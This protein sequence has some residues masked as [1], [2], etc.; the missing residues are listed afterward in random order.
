MANQNNTTN[1]ETE[2]IQKKKNRFLEILKEIVSI[3]KSPACFEALK[4]C[5]ENLELLTENNAMTAEALD[6]LID[7]TSELKGKIGT[8]N[9]EEILQEMA[10]IEEKMKYE[11]KTNREVASSFEVALTQVLDNVPINITKTSLCV[12]VN[13]DYV[14]KM[15]DDNGASYYSRVKT[16]SLS[17]DRSISFAPPEA[18]YN[19]VK[20]E[21]LKDLTDVMESEAKFETEFMKTVYPDFCDL[22]TI[23]DEEQ[24]EK[25]KLLSD[26][27]SFIEKY[28]EIH[29]CEDNPKYN[30]RLVGNTFCMENTSAH[31]LIKF[32]QSDNAIKPVLYSN[33]E[34]GTY[35][36]IGQGISLGSIQQYPDC[37]KVNAQLSFDAGYVL[38]EAIKTEVFSDYL[39]HIGLSKESVKFMMHRE[40]IEGFHKVGD[41]NVID[42]ISN[43]YSR[44]N[45]KLPKGYEAKFINDKNTYIK[46]Q[47]PS[48][49]NVFI[50]FKANGDI[51]RY[52]LWTPDKK[53]IKSVIERK[54]DN[55]N[56][57]IGDTSTVFGENKVVISVKGSKDKDFQKCVQIF[58]EAF[59]AEKKDEIKKE[60]RTIK[61]DRAQRLL[62]TL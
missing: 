42:R 16:L 37:D 38:N 35:S 50:S 10:N 8:L 48:D 25:I 18:E 29:R 58:E 31:K 27:K 39:V 40:G 1:A 56:V 4:K 33:Y 2:V 30:V 15:S 32:E 5:E 6:N 34:R 59:L 49:K 45:K 21:E 23:D 24:K 54:R 53:D 36:T 43:V 19:T 47:T 22:S 28:R 44:V 51:D 55:N 14:F 26:R 3:F 7:L 60:Q 13:G 17:G 46:I 57:E 61:A 11:G 20:M 9:E 62:P 52:S 12:D 41:A